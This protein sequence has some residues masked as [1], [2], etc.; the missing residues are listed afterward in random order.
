MTTDLH[1]LNQDYFEI[2][3]KMS[4]V[5]FSMNLALVRLTNFAKKLPCGLSFYHF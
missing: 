1:I 4:I 2:E 3:E 5:K